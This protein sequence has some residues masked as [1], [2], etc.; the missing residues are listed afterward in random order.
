MTGMMAGP[1]GPP[2]KH[3][4]KLTKRT[5][6]Q[7][8]QTAQTPTSRMSPESRPRP[9]CFRGCQ[10]SASETAIEHGPALSG[11]VDEGVVEG[12]DDEGVG[13]VGWRAFF[14]FF[15]CGLELA[16]RRGRVQDK[17]DKLVH[18]GSMQV[19]T[20]DGIT[21]WLFSDGHACCAAAALSA[22][23]PAPRCRGKAWAHLADGRW[24]VAGGS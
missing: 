13:C 1:D 21:S 20:G 2:T 4:P 12:V 15:F 7:K 16:E 19:S 14:F 17:H 8:A 10:L 23:F 5:S 18:A 9:C 22:S 24:Q 11:Q 6:R 3:F